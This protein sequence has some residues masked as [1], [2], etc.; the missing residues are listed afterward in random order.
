MEQNIRE[1]RLQLDKDRDR[2]DKLQAK[3]K[4]ISLN[5]PLLN[6]A[7]TIEDLHQRLGEYRKGQKDRTRLDGMRIINRKDGAALI[8][9]I[10]PELKPEDADSLRPVLGK[11]RTIQTLSS[12]YEA[13]TQQALQ[14]CKQKD[15][16]E[17]ELKKITKT[18]SG[19]P[20]ARGS[21]GLAKAM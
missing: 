3:Q 14:A 15:E 11:K 5:Q 7:E 9:E 6:H 19:L 18:L 13:L 1:T 8:K 10:R 4:D 20:S 16:A 21:D 17:K 2:L 12:Q